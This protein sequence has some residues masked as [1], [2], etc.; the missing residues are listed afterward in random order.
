[1][2]VEATSSLVAIILIITKLSSCYHSADLVFDS[3]IESFDIDNEVTS[4]HIYAGF[5]VLE[6]AG[7]SLELDMD[8]Y[9]SSCQRSGQSI[10]I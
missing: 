1:M 4:S 2:R 7:S 8:D 9:G 10:Q 3:H 6:S 5:K